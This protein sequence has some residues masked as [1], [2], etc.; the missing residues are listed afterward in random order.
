[1]PA[2]LALVAGGGLKAQAARRDK[3]L[4][5][6]LSLGSR[7]ADTPEWQTQFL[8]S[9]KTRGWVV[10][11]N[12]ELVHAYADWHRDRLEG[13]AAE[14]IGKKV[15]VI[16]AYGD[17]LAVA[18]AARLTKTLPI[19]FREALA[20]IEQGFVDSYAK[21]GRNLTGTTVFAGPDFITKRLEFLRAVAPSASRLIWLYGNGS[22]IVESLNGG[23][24]DVGQLIEQ[25]SK[26]L[27]FTT[28]IRTVREPAEVAGAL[29]AAAAWGAQAI[30]GGGVPVALEQEQVVSFALKARLP[31]VFSVRDYVYAGGLLSYGVPPDEYVAMGD[32]W[33]DQIDKVLRGAQPATLP[34]ELPRRFE[35]CINTKT[36]KAIGIVIPLPLLARADEIVQ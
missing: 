9:M 24:F 15:D 35:L 27:G 11:K 13:L 30:S 4:V 3:K 18:A 10:G 29:S 34:V 25:T 17:E 31:T 33:A 20:P 12:V 23:T 14:L 1:L 19:V 32:R 8:N 26:S 5:G 6:V 36:A 21:P 22:P 16:V 28:R 2:L 7:P